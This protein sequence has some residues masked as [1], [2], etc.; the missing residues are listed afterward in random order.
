MCRRRKGFR[1]LGQILCF[2]VLRFAEG[3][4]AEGPLDGCWGGRWWQGVDQHWGPLTPGLGEEAL[5]WAKPLG[6]LL[7]SRATQLLVC[8]ASFWELGV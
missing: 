7:L 2:P 8:L 5:W 4:H 3:T 6:A 1:H